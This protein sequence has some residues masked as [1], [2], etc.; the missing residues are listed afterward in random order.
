MLE[1]RLAEKFNKICFKGLENV[2]VGDALY[3]HFTQKFSEIKYPVIKSVAKMI[4]A[5]F[6]VKV[7]VEIDKNGKILF[8]FS[9]S[10]G[11]RKDLQRW[12]EN[13][14]ETASNKSVIRP[15]K[16][17]FRIHNISRIT[18][19]IAWNKAV[20]EI[21]MQ[22]KERLYYLATLM[23]A[24]SDIWYVEE[25]LQKNE[26]N[27]KLFVSTCDVH[28]VDSIM[29][30]RFNSHGIDTASLQ[31]G[32]LSR[33]VNSWALTGSKSKYYLIYGEF[34]KDQALLAGVKE[35]KLVAL[36]MPQYIENSLPTDFRREEKK[37]F[38]VIL[39][40]IPD[41]DKKMLA[42]AEAFAEKNNMKY[43]IKMHPGS[44]SED[45]EN[46]FL[47]P[48]IDKVYKDEINVEVFGQFIEFGIINR[49]TVFMEY[50]LSLVPA[51]LYVDITGEDMYEGIDG[52]KFAD[53]QELQR[54][55]DRLK[56]R[57]E[58]VERDILGTRAY[59]VRCDDVKQN[60]MNFFHQYEYD[61]KQG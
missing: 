27:L 16:P 19:F 54:L 7:E 20:S 17:Y 33:K 3:Y 12:F 10:Y 18:I 46:I 22:W 39:D 53:V 48:Y 55:F 30:Q 38:G 4:L 60:Y 43:L 42:I 11:G 1:R 56:T 61:Q 21:G 9:N 2:Q 34:T 36:G 14:C 32:I 13:V 25:I 59:L 23:L 6:F 44:R 41:E 37:L 35:E 58:D 31:H 57:R 28:L 24:M 52:C 15:V 8:L 26:V 50:V 40:G 51:F 49:S 45:Y 5:T 29:T 47:S